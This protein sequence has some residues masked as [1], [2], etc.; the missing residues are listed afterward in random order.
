MCGSFRVRARPPHSSRLANRKRLPAIAC[1]L[2]ALLCLDACGGDAQVPVRDAAARV[3]APG[4]VLIVLDTLRADAV[5]LSGTGPTQLPSLRAFADGATGFSDAI[6]SAAWTPQSMPSLLTGLSPPHTGCEGMAET[7]V[8]ELPGAVVTLAERLRDAGYAT[9]AYTGGGWLGDA[10]GIGQGFDTLVNGFDV[11]GPEACVSAFARR[12]SPDAPFFLMLHSYAPHDP[13][14]EKDPRAMASTGLPPVP[15]SLTLRRT[16]ER[17]A[18]A[19]DS[20]IA[21]AELRDCAYD[22]F[23]DGPARPANARMVLTGGG[24]GL[25]RALQR[26]QDGGYLADPDGRA[27]IEERF[28][29]AYQA[30]LGLTD[31][32]LVRTFAALERAKLPPDTIVVVTSDHGEA[33]GEHGY[34][35]HERRLYEEILRVPLLIRAPGRLPPG[36]VVAGTCGPVDLTPTLLELAGIPVPAGELDGRSLVAQALGRE[37]GHPI[38]A[39]ADRYEVEGDRTR[40]VREITV[41]DDR[42]VWSYVYDVQTGE[43]LGETVVDL[44][45]DPRALDPR[46]VDDVSWTDPEFCRLVAACRDEAR[47]RF[48]FPSIGSYCAAPR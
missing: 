38:V 25:G 22:W 11:L 24:H 39:T 43:P 1:A 45:D 27:A 26:W 31:G 15:P 36:A 8:P 48:G 47:E 6:A 14:G 12:R 4:I 42:R 33:H 46:P 17:L 20:G 23:L 13:Y 19:P 44:V 16:I 35:L 29:S 41:R 37:G 32:L 9:T 28:R 40:S 21:P 10:R 3:R 7:S 30:G 2:V 5:P 34:L 18:N